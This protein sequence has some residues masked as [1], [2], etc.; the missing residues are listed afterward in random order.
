MDKQKPLWTKVIYF[1]HFCC[2]GQ[3]NSEK[4]R[5]YDLV[6]LLAVSGQINVGQKKAVFG[7]PAK[8]TRTTV[9]EIWE[10]LP[11][12]VE[13]EYEVSWSFV[14]WYVDQLYKSLK[15]VTVY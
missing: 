12:V 8:E 14:A 9:R 3:S 4:Y 2:K 5:K 6:I 7:G 1:W 10:I 11:H 15:Y 13:I